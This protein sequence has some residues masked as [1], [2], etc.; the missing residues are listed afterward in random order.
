MIQLP[1]NKS[2]KHTITLGSQDH[3]LSQYFCLLVNK[4]GFWSEDTVLSAD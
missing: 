2:V 4:S 1:K 3:A